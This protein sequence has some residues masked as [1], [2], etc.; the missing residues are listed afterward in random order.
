[1]LELAGAGLR[2]L[3]VRDE[4]K[5]DVGWVSLL[6]MGLDADGICGINEDAGV[7]GGD[8]GFNDR[9]QIVDVRE[10][11]YAEDDIVVGVFA[12]GSVFRGTDD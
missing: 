3:H 12:G 7:L 4:G 6:E 11:F 8:D 5:D 9:G 2:D 10:R 1:M